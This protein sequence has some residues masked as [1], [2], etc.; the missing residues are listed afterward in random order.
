MGHSYDS[1][2]YLSALEGLPQSCWFS[3]P[4]NQE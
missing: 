1:R 4:A 2:E 3:I